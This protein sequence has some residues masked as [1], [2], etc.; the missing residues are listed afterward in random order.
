MEDKNLST[1]Q[2][3]LYSAGQTSMDVG[4]VEDAEGYFKHSSDVSG[5]LCNPYTK[6][7][8]MERQGEAQWRLGKIKEAQETWTDA[9]NL[10]KQFS[11]TERA[12]SVLD[13][14]IAMYRISGMS[15]E[16]RAC[17]HEMAELAS[18]AAR[19]A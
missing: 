1:L 8:A 9:K 3:G 2:Q 14:M 15:R 7:D 13:R 4:K 16:A 17:E 12:N 5:K 19:S 6:C 10:A 11:Y 18:G